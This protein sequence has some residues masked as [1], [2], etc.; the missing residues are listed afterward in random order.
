MGQR[1]DERVGALRFISG[2]THGVKRR[3]EDVEREDS[4]ID[5]RLSGQT[6]PTDT[7]SSDLEIISVRKI[8]EESPTKRRRLSREED[9]EMEEVMDENERAQRRIMELVN[10][11]GTTGIWDKKKKFQTEED[12]ALTPLEKS[13]KMRNAQRNKPFRRIIP[14]PAMKE[15][16]DSFKAKGF[17]SK[18][19]VLNLM[20]EKW[21]L[22][23]K[24]EKT[25]KDEMRTQE[26]KKLLEETE[27]Q[28]IKCGNVDRLREYHK[29]MD[30]ITE[31]L[32]KGELEVRIMKASHSFRACSNT[33]TGRRRPN[34]TAHPR[35]TKPHQRLP[36][37]P[38]RLPQPQEPLHQCRNR[39]RNPFTAQLW[40]WRRRLVQRRH[41]RLL[42]RT[43]L[44]PCQRRPH[45]KESPRLHYL[46]L[47]LHGPRWL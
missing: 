27:M 14:R 37:G 1:A 44:L 39:A 31:K 25:Y 28:V 16:P 34:P 15:L 32:K 6:S 38:K 10:R 13:L 22:D 12:E 21:D 33:L 26:L 20:K 30:I 42:P 45:H 3:L 41:D 5:E 8:R 29:D 43:R 7:S 18:A 40:L 11:V 17:T 47:L 19:D 36:S 46:L 2:E 23:T 9:V 24:K 35:R 4:S